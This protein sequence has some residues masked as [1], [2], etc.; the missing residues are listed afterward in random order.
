MTGIFTIH[1]HN[2]DTH[3]QKQ[4][5]ECIVKPTTEE[6]KLDYHNPVAIYSILYSLVRVRIYTQFNPAESFASF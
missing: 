4:R 6:K 5:D 1:I 3:A 2:I